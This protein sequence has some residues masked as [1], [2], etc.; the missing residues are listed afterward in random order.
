MTYFKKGSLNRIQSKQDKMLFKN[1]NSKPKVY[2]PKK[3]K[4]NKN[5]S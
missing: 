4:I 2:K 3:T 5:F 1:F